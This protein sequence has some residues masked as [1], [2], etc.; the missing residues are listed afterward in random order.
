MGDNKKKLVLI[1]TLGFGKTSL[2]NR[3]TGANIK[4]YVGNISDTRNIM[5]G[6]SLA[7]S[8][9]KSFEVLDTPGLDA[10][11]DKM[12]HIAGILAAL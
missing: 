12:Q 8:A 3:L 7:E 1:G 5:Q 6:F 9:V 4:T 2:F 11:E 10:D